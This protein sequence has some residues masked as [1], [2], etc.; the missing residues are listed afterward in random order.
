MTGDSADEAPEIDGEPLD[1]D[2]E[3]VQPPPEL[4]QI[5]EIQ[6][7]KKAADAEARA[8]PVKKK[9]ADAE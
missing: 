1:A 9:G 4:V 6:A 8:N 7:W 5:H 3:D 2:D